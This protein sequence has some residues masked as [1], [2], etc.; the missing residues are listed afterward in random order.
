M[1]AGGEFSYTFVR[2]ND[3]SWALAAGSDFSYTFVR[4]SDTPWAMAAGGDFP[5]S[6]V[7]GNDTPRARHVSL[8]KLYAKV[9]RTKPGKGTTLQRFVFARPGL[10]KGGGY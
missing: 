8:C 10:L 7:R 1:T 3:T 5:Y 6:F 4:G 9:T 2:G